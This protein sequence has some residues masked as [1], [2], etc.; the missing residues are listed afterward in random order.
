MKL[1]VSPAQSV[2]VFW[3]LIFSK[4]MCQYIVV[5]TAD[6]RLSASDSQKGYVRPFKSLLRNGTAA[7]SSFSALPHFSWSLAKLQ[8]KRNNQK[9]VEAECSH[10]SRFCETV[11]QPVLHFLPC[12][13]FHGL[14]Q[15]CNTNVT[16]K[17]L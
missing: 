9:S 11:Q 13:I 14:W 16:T 7:R 8:H 4:I 17:N 2:T 5:I 6:A 12:H 3:F 15:N 1:S 10:S